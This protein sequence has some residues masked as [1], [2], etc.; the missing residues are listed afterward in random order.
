RL[1][2]RDR[3]QQDLTPQRALDARTI[4]GLQLGAQLLV[5]PPL[6]DRLC[7]HP[8]EHVARQ[9]LRQIERIAANE[10]VGD[11]AFD[12]ALDPHPLL[13]LEAEADARAP[14]LDRFE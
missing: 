13:P 12:L 7:D 14:L 9:A 6:A 11:R 8:V 2:A 10:L 3:A 4:A 1:L 5:H